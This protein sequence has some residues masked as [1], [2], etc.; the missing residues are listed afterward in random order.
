MRQDPWNIPEQDETHELPAEEEPQSPNVEDESEMVLGVQK[1]FQVSTRLWYDIC[2]VVAY[3]IRK[4]S[5]IT[6]EN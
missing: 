4:D 3:N 2:R 6:I 1:L 5:N